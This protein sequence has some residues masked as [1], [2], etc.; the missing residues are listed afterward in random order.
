MTRAY[1]LSNVVNRSFIFIWVSPAPRNA[2]TNINVFFTVI[3]NLF[4]LGKLVLPVLSRRKE[5]SLLRYY[6][7]IFENE[8]QNRR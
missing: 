4:H 1:C 8:S 7:T 2:K 5:L 3:D 6:F